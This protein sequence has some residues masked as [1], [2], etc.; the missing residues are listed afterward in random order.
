MQELLDIWQAF[1]LLC[2]HHGQDVGRHLN[3]PIDDGQRFGAVVDGHSICWLVHVELS[4]NVRLVGRGHVEHH[5]LLFLGLGEAKH[6]V[7]RHVGL[8]H[9]L[10]HTRRRH[11]VSQWD[12]LWLEVHSLHLLLF[13]V[14][15]VLHK[16]KKNP[17]KPSSMSQY[18][19]TAKSIQNT[20]HKYKPWTS[21]A[22]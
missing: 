6:H 22:D 8:A 15:Q 10:A 13:H 12:H 11:L 17:W 16:H 1:S 9:H 7:G 5:G 18:F 19:I 4:W 21:V 3:R 14:K 2:T 20:Y